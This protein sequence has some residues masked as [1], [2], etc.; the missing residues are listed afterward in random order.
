VFETFNQGDALSFTIADNAG[1]CFGAT[2]LGK[3]SLAFEK[4]YPYGYH[5]KVRLEDGVKDPKPLLTVKLLV[6]LSGDADWRPV[7]QDPEPPELEPLATS[8]DTDKAGS[9]GAPLSANVGGLS[10]T[11]PDVAHVHELLGPGSQ[12]L[13]PLGAN[14]STAPLGSPLG[15]NPSSDPLVGPSLAQTGV[16]T[17]YGLNTGATSSLLNPGAGQ[18]S[19]GAGLGTGL[20]DGRNDGRP[21]P[22]LMPQ[23]A[24]AL[25][26]DKQMKAY[27]AVVR[28]M[29]YWNLRRSIELDRSLLLD[30]AREINKDSLHGTG[31]PGAQDKTTDL[32]RGV[33]AP[34][35]PG[36][37]RM[38]VFKLKGAVDISIPLS[39]DSRVPKTKWDEI[40]KQAGE[41]AASAL[42]LRLRFSFLDAPAGLGPALYGHSVLSPKLRIQKAEAQRAVVEAPTSCFGGGPPATLGKLSVTAFCDPL[43]PF[44][45]CSNTTGP[46]RQLVVEVLAEMEPLAI[47]MASIPDRGH[48]ILPG[49]GIRVRADGWLRSPEKHN[50]QLQG[51]TGVSLL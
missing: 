24:F 6:K 49:E 30:P 44:F 43:P 51:G 12:D 7:S 22:V 37:D 20:L 4:L 36:Q 50:L 25:R 42:S 19:V 8:A 23:D 17:G 35:A 14:S 1:S 47:D 13:P 41:E 26:E 16:G 38:F 29:Q 2:K 45:F 31:Q 48:T 5:G 46:N 3:I 34:V 9:L 18:T 11:N 39:A 21:A 27:D 33:E 28:W 40:R 32:L 10:T 15:L